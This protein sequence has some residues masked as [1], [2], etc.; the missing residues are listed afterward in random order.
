MPAPGDAHHR[1]IRGPTWHPDHTPQTRLSL[2]KGHS[3]LLAPRSD[4]Q[5][6]LFSLYHP[7]VGKAITL[8]KITELEDE[9]ALFKP[10]SATD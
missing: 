4:I 5:P 7:I 6:S 9:K 3:Q 1:E 2:L 10:S 8:P